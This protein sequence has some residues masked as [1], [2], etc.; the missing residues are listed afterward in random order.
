MAEDPAFKDIP[1][2]MVTSIANTD[3]SDAVS[4]GREHQHR[5][6]FDQTD[7]TCGSD[8]KDEEILSKEQKI[9]DHGMELG[10]RTGGLNGKSKILTYGGKE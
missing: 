7:Q 6:L 10:H 9:N 3:Y 5:R 4:R 2:I 8:R 1:I